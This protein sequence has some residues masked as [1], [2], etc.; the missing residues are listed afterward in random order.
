MDDWGVDVAITGSQKALMLPPGL[1]LRRPV[2]SR[3]GGRGQEQGR[4]ELL[5]RPRRYRKSL[6]DGDTPFTPA[7]T[8]IEALR[9]SL[10]MIKDETLETR[11]EAHRTPSPRPSARA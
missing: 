7:N 9:V 8:L 10:R 11:L 5:P 1:A 3:L 2:R 6:D 4:H